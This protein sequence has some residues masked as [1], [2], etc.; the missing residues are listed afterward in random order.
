MN[1]CCSNATTNCCAECGEEGGGDVS[2]KACKS[3]WLVKYCN[4]KC[5]KKHWSRHKK[6]CKQRAAEL[7]DE[8]LFKDPPPKEDCPICFL[9]M[10]QKLV[11]CVSLPPATITSVPIWDFAEANEELAHIETE[12]YFS[13]CG[14]SICVGCVNSFR[15]SGNDV[16][17]FCKAKISGKTDEE[18]LEE[19]RK[20]MAANDPGAIYLLANYYYYGWGSLEQDQTKAIKLYIRAADL[21]DSQAHCNLGKVYYEGGDLTKAKFHYEAAAMAGLDV[22][23]LNIGSTEASSG[24]MDRAVKHW[25]IAAS[26][27]NYQAMHAVQRLFEEGIVSRDAIESTLAAYNNSCVEMRS[28]AREAYIRMQL[29]VTNNTSL[30]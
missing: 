14:K 8:A 5:Q 20:R 10:L 4:A 25:T 16:C 9:P 15:K 13:C 1:N 28:E 19:L 22:A 27:G 24:N 12:E 2:L 18:Q 7:R 21:G 29:A 3:C 30:V 11:C 23:R 26:A 17:P 6:I